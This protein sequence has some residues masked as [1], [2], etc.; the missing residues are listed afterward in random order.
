MTNGSKRNNARRERR[1]AMGQAILEGV[2]AIPAI[3]KFIEWMVGILQ[4]WM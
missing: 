3:V 1:L 4:N 2:V